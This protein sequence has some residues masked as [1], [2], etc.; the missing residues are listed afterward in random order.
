[1][2]DASTPHISRAMVCHGFHQM[3]IELVVGVILVAHFTGDLNT[4]DHKSSAV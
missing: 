3:D 4:I 1:M 2:L